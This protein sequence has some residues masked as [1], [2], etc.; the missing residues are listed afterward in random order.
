MGIKRIVEITKW[1]VGPN[2]SQKGESCK[3]KG[4]S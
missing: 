2:Y 3:K 4:L 1:Q